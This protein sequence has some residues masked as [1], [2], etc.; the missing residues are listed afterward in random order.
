MSHP[1]GL[2]GGLTRSEDERPPPRDYDRR[3]DRRSGGYDRYDDRERGD[4]SVFLLLRRIPWLVADYVG[5]EGEM[6]NTDLV[7]MIE[8]I[9]TRGSDHPGMSPLSEFLGAFA[10]LAVPVDIDV[11]GSRQSTKIGEPHPLP[12]TMMTLYLQ[13]MSPR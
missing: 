3:D 10:D 8:E 4:R 7:A 13:V 1:R 9:D 6:T 2:E 12:G 5:E 11:R